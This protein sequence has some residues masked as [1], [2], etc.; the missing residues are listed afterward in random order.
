VNN[1]I[2]ILAAQINS[3]RQSIVGLLA[4]CS[5]HPADNIKPITSGSMPALKAR[6]P[7]AC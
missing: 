4:V 6:T 7:K 2:N 5:N 1:T 3:K